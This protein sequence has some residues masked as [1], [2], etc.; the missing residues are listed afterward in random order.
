[1]EWLSSAKRDAHGRSLS[2]T[3]TGEPKG[4][5]HTTEGAGWP[6]YQGWTVHPHLTV[7]PHAGKGVEVRQHVPF[8][9]ASFALRNLPG[10]AQTNRDRVYQIELVGTC[11]KSIARR[12]AY[13]W[14]DADDAVL[15]DLFAKVIGPMSEHLGIPLRAL[16][17]QPYP[18][19]Y[20][21]RGRTNTCRLSATAFDRYSGWLGHQHVPENS[22]GDPGGFPW[23]RMMTLRD[24]DDM[25]LTKE[26]VRLNWTGVKV[27]QNENESGGADPEPDWTPAQAMAKADTKLDNL[28]KAVKANSVALK[29]VLKAVAATSPE[30]VSEAFD[31]GIAELEKALSG[32]DVR[33]EIGKQP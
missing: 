26:D 9:R 18:A 22:H 1:M 28:T 19:S 29:A 2:F 21:P 15:R 30:A 13:Y 10:G 20:G 16:D 31:E 17:F 5:L 14:P 32:L 4:C 8:S 25:P 33:I 24:G 23:A 6:W 7:L 11:D 3:D 27:I 12:G